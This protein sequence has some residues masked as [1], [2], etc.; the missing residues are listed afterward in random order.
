MRPAPPSAPRFGL[1]DAFL[2]LAILAF[3]CGFL[4]QRS[5]LG[6][7]AIWGS[8]AAAALAYD[9]WSSRGGWWCVGALMLAMLIGGMPLWIPGL[10]FE[11]RSPD[12]P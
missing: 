12:Q 8:G 7:A 3:F 4:A 1:G 5:L 9:W 10:W 6:L 11:L 2:G